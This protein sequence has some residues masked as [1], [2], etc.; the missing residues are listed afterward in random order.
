ML[1]NCSVF[2]QQSEKEAVAAIKRGK[3]QAV[4]FD[5]IGVAAQKSINLFGVFFIEQRARRVGK[6]PPWTH[7]KG[8]FLK[9]PLL[10]VGQ[11]L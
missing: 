8:R 2:L 1:V 5:P 7:E 9:Y 10:E 6:M 11:C 4:G 3:L